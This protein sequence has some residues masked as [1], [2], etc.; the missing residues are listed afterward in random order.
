[1]HQILVKMAF[2]PLAPESRGLVPQAQ[3]GHGSPRCSASRSPLGSEARSRRH[4]PQMPTLAFL[5]SPKPVARIGK[6]SECPGGL[7]EEPGKGF[8]FP[9]FA[10]T[11][12]K[13][14][15]SLFIAGKLFSTTRPR[16]L[17]GENPLERPPLPVLHH[18]NPAQTPACLH[19]ALTP[20]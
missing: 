4:K 16:N 17:R 6:Y 18:T 13:V 3:E 2:Y 7:L 11:P 14:L 5:F 8:P 10:E 15:C 19:P 20:S 9:V 12:R 1:M